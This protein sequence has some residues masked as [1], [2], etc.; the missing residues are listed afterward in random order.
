MADVTLG[1]LRD[2]GALEFGDG[3]RT[4]RTE[5]GQPGYRILRVTD[6]RDGRINLDSDDFVR[7]EY[8][9]AIGAKLSQPGD[10]LLTTK[11]TVGRVAIYPANLEPVVYSP[12][13]CFFRV[14]DLDVLHPRFLAYWFKSM[15]FL[16]QATHRAN[17]T[18]MAAYI[19]LRDIQTLAL[20]LPGI[21]EQRAIADVLGALDDKIVTNDRCIETAR[22]LMLMLASAAP[23]EATLADLAEPLRRAMN[24]A[25]FEPDV[26]LF[27]LPAFDGRELPEACP[28][29]SIKSN[30]FALGSPCVLLSKLNP[31]F[32]RIWDVSML[33]EAMAVAS[34]EF[35]VLVPREVSTSLLWASL[36]Q[37]S[38]QDELVSK[39][40]GTSGSH[41]RIR[42]SEIMQL[43]VPDPRSLELASQAQITSL[44]RLCHARRME[45]LRLKTTRDELLPLLMSRKV[46]ARDAENVVEEVA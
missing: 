34:T 42:P 7:R 41:Q 4:K 23:G 10:V 5:H 40:S 21:A 18:D 32:P 6:I 20:N 22:Q 46:R 31:R 39:V 11:G 2:A 16:R 27:S 45:S 38:V 43:E 15:S 17:N 3:Y 36:G 24:P 33:P 1:E 14:R 29:E 37:R 44:G 13:V 9:P 26:A 28:R 8:S 19:N 12:Q 25:A 30:K 35:V